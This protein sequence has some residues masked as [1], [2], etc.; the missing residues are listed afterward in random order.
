MR[1]TVFILA[2]LIVAA[3]RKTETVSPASPVPA[4]PLQDLSNVKTDVIAP[5]SVAPGKTC[6]HTTEIEVT[7]IVGQPMKFEES[8]KTECKLVAAADSKSFFVFDIFDG[9]KKFDEVTRGKTFEPL[10]GIG[11][12]AAVDSSSGTVVAVKNNHTYVGTFAT[13]KDKSVALAQKI[14][15]RL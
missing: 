12:K 2:L 3:C 10:S 7:E 6:T 11:E 14:V 5:L 9:A 8:K 15:S 4:K 1:K 13:S